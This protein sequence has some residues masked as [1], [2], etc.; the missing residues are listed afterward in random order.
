MTVATGPAVS[1][2]PATRSVIS[3]PGIFVIVVIFLSLSDRKRR[4]RSWSARFLLGQFF[5]DSPRPEPAGFYRLRG[6]LPGDV[7]PQLL[8]TYENVRWSLSRCQAAWCS[9]KTVQFESPSSA[10]LKS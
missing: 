3:T 10:S 5:A 2:W 9:L 4:G 8:A 1:P 6:P 7:I